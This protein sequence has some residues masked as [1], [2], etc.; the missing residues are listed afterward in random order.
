MV[1]GILVYMKPRLAHIYIVS[2]AVP[3]SKGTNKE[4]VSYR[5]I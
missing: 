4:I 1:S 3:T 5:V 2:T